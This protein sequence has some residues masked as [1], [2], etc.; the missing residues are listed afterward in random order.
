MYREAHSESLISNVI[1][2]IRNFSR[3]A[4]YMMFSWISSLKFLTLSA[5]K[6][7]FMFFPPQIQ[8]LLIPEQPVAA[9]IC[10][11][12]GCVPMLSF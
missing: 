5:S 11:V 3:L 10:Q 1:L 12:A 9:E 8:I 2:S 7:I 6:A 4:L